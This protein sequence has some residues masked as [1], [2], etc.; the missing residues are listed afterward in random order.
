MGAK[1]IIKNITDFLNISNFTLN[2]KK[3]A[4]KK[5]LFKLK[6]K[7]VEALRELKKEPEAEDKKK[8]QEELE[9]LSFHI[10]KAKKKLESE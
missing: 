3:K 4:L 5:L 2:G 1:K 10:T 7:R 8:L 6:K 9:L